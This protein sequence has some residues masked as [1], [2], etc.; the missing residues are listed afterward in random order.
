MEKESE[1]LKNVCFGST[2][3]RK[4]FPY[5]CA[6][7]RLGNELAPIRGSSNIGPGCYNF[8]E[9]TNTIHLQ[10]RK[11]MSKKGYT[12]G[13]RTAQRF[14]S[15]KKIETPGPAEYQSFWSKE[16]RVSASWAPFNIQAV[17][18]PDKMTDISLNPSPGT[19]E[20]YI[21][22]GRKVS[23]PGRFGSPDWSS[24]PSLEKRTLRSELSTDK[25]FRKNRNRVAYLSLYYS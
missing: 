24:V 22:L 2:Q 15:N 10:N 4:Q 13:A 3:D 19:Y 18:F 7:D 20:H 25:E 9:V 11:P 17:R 12:L 8:E 23:W 21:K 14:M 1:T 16:K 5:Y 6:P